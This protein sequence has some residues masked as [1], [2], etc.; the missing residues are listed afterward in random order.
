MLHTVRVWE[1]IKKKIS[2]SRQLKFV[3]CLYTSSCVT[4][5]P[6]ESKQ[7][8]I[9]K[10]KCII[11]IIKSLCKH[12]CNGKSTIA[13]F[14]P[15]FCSRLPATLCITLAWATLCFHLRFRM[16]AASLLLLEIHLSWK[17]KAHCRY[18]I[19]DEELLISFSLVC[20][21]L[22]HFWVLEILV[23]N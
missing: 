19:V 20:S 14:L 10:N 1:K 17:H 8:K 4:L 21:L 13:I 16:R 7:N 2:T 3:E 18:E 22:I 11:N 5:T 6:L 12:E 9:T 23:L 15:G